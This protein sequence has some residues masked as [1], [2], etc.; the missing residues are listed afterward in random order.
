MLLQ[1]CH[2]TRSKS[3]TNS[4]K[5]CWCVS[6]SVIFCPLRLFLAQTCSLHWLRVTVSESCIHL[7]VSISCW[8]TVVVAIYFMYLNQ[9][10]VHCSPLRAY[11][12]DF[13]FIFAQL[14]ILFLFVLLRKTFLIFTLC[15]TA[16]RALFCFVLLHFHRYF[17][18]KQF[19]DGWDITAAT[20]FIRFVLKLNSSWFVPFF[21]CKITQRYFC[22]CDRNQSN[23]PVNRNG[24]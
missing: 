2:M 5:L 3:F 22:D 10:G 19:A 7:I 11:F 15:F 14:L 20:I 8:A 12:S 16:L 23:D 24:W 1:R 4:T 17:V 6:L 21:S 13:I 9:L 18:A